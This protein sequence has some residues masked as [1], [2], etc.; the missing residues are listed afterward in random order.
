MPPINAN[1]ILKPGASRYRLSVNRRIVMVNAAGQRVYPGSIQSISTSQTKDVQRHYEM[2]SDGQCYE[3]TQGL[4]SDIS[5]T[6]NKLKLN[7]S[8]L[9][10]EFTGVAGIE[11]LYSAALPFD[12]EDYILVPLIREDGTISPFRKDATER[13]IK[14][15]RDCVIQ[16]YSD[17]S[18]I[19]GDLAETEDATIQVREI[20]TQ[21]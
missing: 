21:F 14:I 19:S 7:L 20:E 2:N 10:S 4:V 6:I 18:T 11:D 13:I 12:V 5:I 8:T 1:D 9:I 17:N 16:S 3:V 15:Y